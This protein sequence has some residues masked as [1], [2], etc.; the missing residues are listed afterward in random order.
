MDG[1][2]RGMNAVR[3]GITRRER[4]QILYLIRLDIIQL[5]QEGMS[6]KAIAALLDVS[7]SHVTKVI[8]DFR[9]NGLAALKPYESGKP[10]GREC[11]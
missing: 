9:Y 7:E 1:R 8:N 6:R 10:W 3:K 11:P 4:N 2:D 5:T